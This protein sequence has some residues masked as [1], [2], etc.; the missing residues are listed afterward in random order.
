MTALCSIFVFDVG[1]SN[2]E[3]YIFSLLLFCL[4]GLAAVN[5]IEELLLMDEIN[6]QNKVFGHFASLQLWPRLIGVHECEIWRLFLIEISCGS[7]SVGQWE[8]LKKCSLQWYQLLTDSR[9]CLRN[10]TNLTIKN[11]QLQEN[12]YIYI[13]YHLIT[14]ALI[15]L[16]ATVETQGE[17]L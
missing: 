7:Q 9:S 13:C 12:Y 10:W 17:W 3:S 4:D 5:L 14:K 8:F 11:K 15:N 6:I 2:S 16:Y 1:L